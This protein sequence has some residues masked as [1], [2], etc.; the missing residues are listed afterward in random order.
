[1][2]A[3]SKQKQ[4]GKRGRERVRDREEKAANDKKPRAIEYCH[5]GK[6]ERVIG[7][8]IRSTVVTTKIRN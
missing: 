7:S 6:Q 5:G 4:R 8:T 3:R 2:T 1:M